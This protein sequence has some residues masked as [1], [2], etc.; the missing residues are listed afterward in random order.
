MLQSWVGAGHW[1][2]DKKMMQD[3]QISMCSLFPE[4][5]W[6]GG[7]RAQ[8]ESNTTSLSELSWIIDVLLE[9]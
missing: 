4:R 1:E 3:Y 6:A 9:R 8:Q 7:C 5:T 2:K